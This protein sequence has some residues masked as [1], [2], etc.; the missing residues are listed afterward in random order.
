M[1]TLE[2]VGWD[3]FLWKLVKLYDENK[4]CYILKKADFY[5]P[6]FACMINNLNQSIST[7]DN[8]AIGDAIQ[9]MVSTSGKVIHGK[10]RGLGWRSRQV[11]GY[12]SDASVQQLSRDMTSINFQ[13]TRDESSSS[14]GNPPLISDDSVEKESTLDF[15]ERH[16]RGFRLMPQPSPDIPTSS[17]DLAG[18]WTK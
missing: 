5:I 18:G 14:P 11:G 16:G 3:N 8:Y 6:L 15:S 2:L 9:F 13:N 4:S 17:K 7:I 10:N 1:H 12:L